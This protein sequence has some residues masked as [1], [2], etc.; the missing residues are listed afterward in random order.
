MYSEYLAEKV[1]PI[2]GDISEDNLGMKSEDWNL[3]AEEVDVIFNI[4]ASVDFIARLDINMR[5]NTRG[6]MN[7]LQLAKACSKIQVLCQISTAYANSQK[8]KGPVEE[9]IDED[10][11]EKLESILEEVLQMSPEEVEEKRLEKLLRK[12]RGNLPLVI[13]RPSMIGAA[14]EEPHIGW[15]DSV[16]ATTA[17]YLAASIGV[18]KDLYG[19]SGIIG[20]EIPVDYVA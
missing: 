16:S 2:E 14:A 10:D 12:Y 17:V 1:F 8:P 18:L 9:T 7:I 19:N 5:I 4:A 20:D 3:L 13:I 11:V 6:A 15:V